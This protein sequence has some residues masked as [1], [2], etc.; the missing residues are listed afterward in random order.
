MAT[1][2][3]IMFRHSVLPSP[4]T[5]HERLPVANDP[6]YDALP[7]FEVLQKAVAFLCRFRSC[8]EIVRDN[9]K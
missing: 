4:K 3:T 8:R 7:A 6:G 1:C 2:L 9:N 5:S